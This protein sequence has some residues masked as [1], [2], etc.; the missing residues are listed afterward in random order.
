MKQTKQGRGFTLLELL[1][2]IAIIAILSVIL[3]LVLNPAETLKKSRDAQR[4][5]DLSTVKTALG[6]YLTATTT[7]YL[8]GAAT[9]G[10]CVDGAT[11]AL[12]IS[13]TGVVGTYATGT[14][15]ISS[16]S[17]TG[18]DSTGWIPVNLSSLTGGSPISNMPLDPVNTTAATTGVSDS[19]LVYRYACKSSPLGF[20]IDAQL[21]SLAYTVEDNKR[22]KDGGNNALIY[23]VGTDLTTFQ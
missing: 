15:L 17:T 9:N 11:K 6:L 16:S 23:E 2:V 8:S 21:E 3:V 19:D 12:F 5:S 13:T 22:S 1:I 20:E 4:I 10:R 7:P 14:L 18:V